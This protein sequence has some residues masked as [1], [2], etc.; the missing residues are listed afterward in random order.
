MEISQYFFIVVEIT[1]R[2]ERTRIHSC[3]NARVF[4]EVEMVNSVKCLTK[5]DT[6]F[7]WIDHKYA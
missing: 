7:H 6:F 4:S 5:E 1:S 2:L 3:Q